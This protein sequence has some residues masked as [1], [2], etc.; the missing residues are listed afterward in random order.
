MI[1]IRK[2]TFRSFLAALIIV[3]MMVGSA[4]LAQEG[5]DNK[6]APLL[7][8]NAW[9]PERYQLLNIN[10]LW[11]WA[12]RNGESCR[13]PNG[14]YGCF[15]PRGK[16]YMLYANG[17]IVGTRAYLDEA[18]TQH[19]PYGQTIRAIGS[20][21]SPGYRQGWVNGL[22]ANATPEDIGNPATRIYRIR[23][24]WKEMTQD[25]LQRDAGESNE[26][27]ITSVADDQ[28][29]KII[30]DY[31]ECWNTWPVGHG[32]PFVDR[33]GNGVYDPP[34]ADFAVKDLI[35][36]GYDE[37]GI[38]GADLNSPAD[39]V[40][41]TIYNDL[42][43]P[44]TRIF[45]SDPIGLEI[46]E[47]KWGYKRTDALGNI[48]FRKWRFINKG[49]VEVD[50]S[51]TMGAFYLDS[52]YVAQWCDMTVGDYTADV[53]G[54][55]TTLSLAFAWNGNA[56]DR[57]FRKFG[58]PP[59]AGGF[60]YLQGPAVP[61]PGDRAVFNLQYKD[62]YKNLGMS[63][64]AYF[65]ASSPYSDP[66]GGYDTNAIRWYKMMRGYA[67]IGA[68]DEDIR[69]NFPPGI[70]PGPF[71]LAGD[72]VTGTGHIDGMGTEYSIQP[73][74]RRLVAISGP[75]QMAPGD[76]NEAVVAFVCGLGGDRFSSISV[77]KFNDRFAQN[78]Y[79][80]LFQVPNPPAAPDV[81]VAE[82]DGNVVLQWGSN[83]ERINDTEN[84]VNEPGG[85]KFEGYNIYQLPTANASITDAKR[86]ATYDLLTDPAAVL[87][88]QFDVASGQ[89]LPTAVQ[90]GT[91]SGISR[92]FVFDH[93][94]LLDVEKL[95]NGIDYYIAVTAYS[96][97]TVPG[98]LPQSLESALSVIKVIPQ[99]SDMGQVMGSEY[100]ETIDVVTHTGGS[101]FA[102]ITPTIIDPFTIVPATYTVAW[103]ADSTWKVMKGGTTIV[104]DQTNYSG[105]ELYPIVD[106]VMVKVEDVIFG[107]PSGFTSA[108]VSPSDNEDN[109][110]LRDRG[111]AGGTTD[112]TLLEGDLE[113]RFTGEYDAKVGT[114]VPIKEGTGSIATIYQSKDLANHPLNPNPGVDE[115]FTMRIPFEVWD[116]ERNMQISV[117][118]RD[119]SQEMTADPFYAFNPSGR[120]Y[121]YFNGLSYQETV[122]TEADEDYNTWYIRFYKT[123]WQTGDVVTIEYANRIIPGEDTFAYSTSGHENT[124]DEELKKKDLERIGVFPNPYYAYNPLEVDKLGRFVTFN[125]LPPSKATIRL[126]AVS[127]H[128]VRVIRKDNDAKF[129]QWD[130][131]NE[132]G[133]PIASGIYVA[134][135]EIP[136]E[137]LSKV[138]KLV[139]VMEAEILDIF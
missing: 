93:D 111:S 9:M 68:A 118:F 124:V 121:C 84:K 5:G 61:S 71:P 131:L 107:A 23:R 20:T 11:E 76:T 51:G 39:Q 7:K 94:Y 49:G 78:T 10:N 82:F 92:T 47:T 85:F 74:D 139:I 46:Q 106:G 90:F 73:G 44:T 75:F 109:Y 50:E 13:S 136:D 28:I 66:G 15:F 26:I 72:P 134:H 19:A 16:T 42:H 3:G 33:N 35:E 112:I 129:L 38:V 96:V 120:M 138:L 31:E 115:R 123:D 137:G 113:L 29:Q 91:N 101:G 83:A 52:V 67:P 126:F 119:Y 54:C 55:D 100:G 89:I 30:D 104:D 24:D 53:L 56:I 21:Y 25:E 18:H 65:S 62:D 99:L 59:A 57:D 60:D 81:Q 86:I 125:N 128:L 87:D 122:I 40:I 69:Y 132:S 114:V 4:S 6:D 22:G 135:I 14:D 48:Y 80:A 58:L 98:F 105:D 1:N 43:I 77:M 79:D 127:G 103:D 88:E 110:D 95:N 37:P 2:I 12:Q 32:A 63:T 36:Q 70:E 130:L 97:T 116:I 8:V 34:P 41:F 17:F 117:V 27:P 133:L 102:E 45:N 108:T 64:F